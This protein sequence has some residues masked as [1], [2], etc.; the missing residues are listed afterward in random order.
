MRKLSLVQ[1]QVVTIPHCRLRIAHCEIE[2]AYTMITLLLGVCMTMVVA[3]A[4]P[5]T[6]VL[7]EHNFISV[8]GAIDENSADQFIR[9][10][11]LLSVTPSNTSDAALR[12]VF[13]DTPGGSVTEGSRMVSE[14]QRMN[15]TCI[16]T[17]A[18]SMGFALL[19][20]CKVR[21]VTPM[22]SLMQHQMTFTIQGE[23]E[24]VQNYMAAF[25][26]YSRALDRMQAKR[27]GLSEEAFNTRISNEWWL[28]GA[29]AI[30]RHNAADG[31]AEVA[32]T[33]DLIRENHT[34]TRASSPSTL[35]AV[36]MTVIETRSRCPLL[37]A[38]LHVEVR[39]SDG[40]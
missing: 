5:P 9:E 40:A 6:V 20:A 8:Q 16:A 34:V 15:Y 23:I 1:Q 17:R 7:T 13:I 24:R 3:R 26:P 19:Q 36:P 18:Y 27:L 31:V 38:P 37:R 32:C 28:F 22:A 35:T 2:L 25:R 4:L 33:P 10:S 30:Y 14:I 39:L 11:M 21:L 29:A 12:Y